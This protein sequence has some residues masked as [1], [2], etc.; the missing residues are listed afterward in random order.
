LSNQNCPGHFF[1]RIPG[2]NAAGLFGL[3]TLAA[4]TCVALFVQQCLHREFF[5]ASAWRRRHQNTFSLTITNSTLSSFQLQP[6]FH[7]A[8]LFVDV[9]KEK[10]FNKSSTFSLLDLDHA[11]EELPKP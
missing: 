10:D 2:E 8:G 11:G 4:S 3:C 9:E 6:I 7:K 1:S 5:Q